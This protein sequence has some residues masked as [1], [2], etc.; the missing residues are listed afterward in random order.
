MTRGKV[1]SLTGHSTKYPQLPKHTPFHP[2]CRHRETPFIETFRSDEE[3]ARIREESNTQGQITVQDPEKLAALM[4]KQDKRA[5]LMAEK[6]RL[7]KQDKADILEGRRDAPKDQAA[8]ERSLT[9][10][11]SAAQ[12]KR[13]QAIEWEKQVSEYRSRRPSEATVKS[14]HQRATAWSGSLTPEEAE[15]SR[16]YKSRFDVLNGRLEGTWKAPNEMAE[17][18][19]RGTTESLISAIEKGNVPSGT[20]LYRGFGSRTGTI[21]LR[22]GDSFRQDGFTSTSIDPS[23]ALSYA[24]AYV[25]KVGTGEAYMATIRVP[26]SMKAAYPDVLKPGSIDL[27]A[28]LRPGITFRVASLTPDAKNARL[29]WVELE[30][31]N[32]EAL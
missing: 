23:V 9:A 28:T 27:E 31:V 21:G 20:A 12:R 3:L 30:I 22:V 1:Y 6:R 5:A 4:E 19:A 18:I 11:A 32:E 7:R 8:Y 10:R 15:A 17:D 13:E 2:N 29:K 25:P 16:I 24:T 14:Y 26:P